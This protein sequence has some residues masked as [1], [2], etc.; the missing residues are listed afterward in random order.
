MNNSEEE[1]QKFVEE[2]T[3]GKSNL[4]LLW[5]TIQIKI[6]VAL[7]RVRIKIKKFFT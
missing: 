2:L 1:I 4:G 3:T 6:I 5:T 7:V